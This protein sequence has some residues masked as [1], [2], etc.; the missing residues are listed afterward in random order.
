MGENG[1]P[2]IATAEP[3]QLNFVPGDKWLVLHIPMGSDK[4]AIVTSPD[5]PVSD[6]VSMLSALMGVLGA[7]LKQDEVKSRIIKVPTGTRI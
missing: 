2:S 6:Q 7:V 4:L 5:L 3:Q 1:K